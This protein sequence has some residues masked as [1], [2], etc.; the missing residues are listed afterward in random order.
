MSR[1]GLDWGRAFA[2]AC[3]LV[4]SLGA[5]SAAPAQPPPSTRAPSAVDPSLQAVPVVPPRAVD[6]GDLSGYVDGVVEGYMRRLGIAGATVA[7]VDRQ[8]PL[9]LRGYGI[10]TQDG[11][12]K[13]DPAR[14][15]FRVGSVSKTFTYLEALKLI[16]AGTLSLDAPVNDYLPADLKLPDDGYPPVLVRHLLTHTAGYEDSALGH[17][18]ADTPEHT[19]TL[20]D[21]LQRHRPARVRAPGV[22]AVYSNY[23]LALLGA[24][25]ARV[26]DVPFESLAE[27]D[28]FG[29]MGMQL[30][31]FREPLGDGDPRTAD[32]RFKGL[33]SDGFKRVDGGFRSEP[34]EYIAQ[35]APAGSVSSNAADMAR[36]LT[37]L[38]NRGELEGRR[39]VPAAAFARLEGEPLFRNAPDATGFAYGFFRKR[40]GEV[41]SLEHGGATMYFHSSLVAVPELGFGV[42]VS[43]NTDSGVRLAAELPQ[44]LLERYFPQARGAALPAPPKDF[45]TRGLVYA[46]KYLGER[47]PFQGFEK[48]LLASSATVGVT[49]DGYLTLTANG[50][51]TRWV[52]EKPNVFRALQGPGRLAFLAGPD[53]RIS[54][55]VSPGG[56]DVFDRAG[57]LD[58][59]QLLFAMLLLATLTALGVI[60]GAW[61]RRWQ[62]RNGEAMSAMLSARWLYATAAAWLLL[63]LVLA[64][65]AQG[66]VKGGDTLM[67]DYPGAWLRIALWLALPAMLLSV[68]CVL[69]LWPAWR[70]RH[71]GFWRKLRHTTAVAIFAFATVLMWSWNMVGWK[72]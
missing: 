10:A 23:S 28:L 40:Y 66:I 14:T 12:R 69:Q 61:L 9:L 53:G 36:Y 54:G 37:M 43:T 2:L 27:R 59:A 18:F 68:V 33:W 25:L 5:M 62:R 48:L 71:W 32:A 50:E 45:A 17:L 24:V 41:Q 19:L 38:V 58:D 4:G 3:V 15:L 60:A 39:I 55:F 65:A 49:D 34:F 1:A 11:P 21:Y 56:H 47:R 35:I 20:H 70:A 8:G 57:V 13:V 30:T 22:H 52:E 51:S 44:L 29:P 7:V 26:N 46:G 16:D 67:Y 72:L 6:A 64:V 42:F 63:A 31:T